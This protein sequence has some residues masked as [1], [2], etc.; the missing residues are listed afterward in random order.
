MKIILVGG[1]SGGHFYPLIAVANALH[2]IAEEERIIFVD[3]TFMGE[4]P[5]DQKALDESEI[6]FEAISAG[7][8]RRYFSI[9][10]FTD[11]FKTL[12]GTAH[13][14]W[15]FTL[16]PPDVVF[17]KGGYDSFPTLWAARIYRIPVMIHESDAVPGAVN[18]WASKFARRI[19]VAFPEAVQFF[20]SEKTALVG[21]PIRRG[22]IGGSEDEAFDIF[23]LES[24]VPVVLVLGGSQGAQ[25]INEVILAAL[26]E[27][28]EVVQIIHSTGEQNFESVKNE[29]EVVLS[30]SLHKKRYH[31]FPSL[32][33]GQMR[34]G[35]FIADVVVSRS[36]AG[37]IFE[38]AAWKTP[39]ILIPI[40][41]S[42]QDHSR[43][44]AYNYARTGAAV[45]LEEANLTPHLLKSEIEK[46]VSNEER[47]KEMKQAA[48]TF[49]K[50]DA[51]RKIANELIRLGVHE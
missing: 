33:V 26:L 25:K 36:G 29:A 46:I 41:N 28:V 21:N 48:G 42:P 37:H 11:I 9:M 49:A 4:K 8:V 30:K 2:D 10:N 5:Y 35:S 32:N 18:K 34:N 38:I 47:K 44:N 1:G 39:A 24:G 6:K 20:P 45:V 17:S 43:E 23:N 31:P 40:T 19:G 51:A 22:I 7:K 3:L 15:K 16:K 12:R 14:F 13:A 27:L 50:L